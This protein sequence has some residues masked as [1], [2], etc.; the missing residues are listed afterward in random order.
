MTPSTVE[1]PS[2]T[3][4]R[5]KRS[6]RTRSQTQNFWFWVHY[7]WNFCNSNFEREIG[8]RWFG[9]EFVSYYAI[10]MGELRF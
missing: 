3:L 7:S 1:Y 6:K 2:P 4:L 8:E 9:F 5:K 10:P